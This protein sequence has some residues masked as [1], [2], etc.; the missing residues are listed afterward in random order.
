MTRGVVVLVR[1]PHRSGTRG[2]RRPA[3]IVQ[4]DKHSSVVATLVV[5][6]VTSN[7]S[8][9]SHP[10]C[11]FVDVSTPEGQSTGLLHNSVVSC[12]AMAT[13]YGD[14]VDQTL[15]SLSPAMMNRLDACL[16]DALGLS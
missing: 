12:L 2:K 8:L 13:V 7:L 16:S 11:L 3:V 14:T 6:E 10:A 9:A 1:F 5:A 15:G 4:A